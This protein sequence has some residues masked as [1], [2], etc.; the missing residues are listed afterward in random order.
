[1]FETDFVNVTE[2]WQD[3][4]YLQVGELIRKED[5]EASRIAEFCA[6]MNKY[7]GTNQLN[8]LYKFL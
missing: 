6:Y 8:L 2:M 1:M 3:G 7:L 4:N 5:W